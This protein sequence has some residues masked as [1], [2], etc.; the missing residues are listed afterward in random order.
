MERNNRFDGGREA[1]EPP[2]RSTLRRRLT[3]GLLVAAVV[4]FLAS[5]A[6]ATVSEL[7]DATWGT[8]GRVYTVLRTGDRIYVG[9]SF[10]AAVAAGGSSV[11]RKNLLALDAATG[12]LVGGFRPEPSG[13]IHS[14]AVSPNG[15]VL[16]VGGRFRSIG[17]ASRRHL[18]AVDA[19]TGTA[20]GSFS[21]SAN[22]RVNALVVGG[23]RL[24]VGGA[25]TALSDPSGSQQRYALGAV[26]I[27]T[28]HVDTSWDARVGGSTPV[29]AMWL[30][31]DGR[32]VFGGDFSNVAGTGR[33]HLAAVDAGTAALDKTF[34]PRNVPVVWGVTGDATR[35]Y[36]ACAGPGG[37]VQGLSATTGAEEWFVHG[38]GNFQGVALL[39]GL[40]YVGGHFGGSNGF[41]GQARYKLAAVNPG[42]GAVDPFN[43]RIDSPLGVFAVH[44]SNNHLY[45]GGDFT[46]VSG[47][48]QPHFAQLTE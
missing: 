33:A 12:A 28:N 48:R 8:N 20:I 47:V 32:L 36:V 40:L 10:S 6:E 4:A 27:A 34:A 38:N 39:G 22:R 15:G 45:I 2:R 9:G 42:T 24:Y 23:G 17:G 11:A 19:G 21:V 5:P 16:Y 13:E 30:S 25:F 31:D 1:P 37:E 29:R 44:A 41:G 14:L 7:P 3:A 46:K 35:V 18:A 26:D 43:P